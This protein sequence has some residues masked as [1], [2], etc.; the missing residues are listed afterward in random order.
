MSGSTMKSLFVVQ[1]EGPCPCRPRPSDWRTRS[2]A[3][4]GRTSPARPRLVTAG[5]AARADHRRVQ[6]VEGGSCGAPQAGKLVTHGAAT[7]FARSGTFA[8]TSASR[9]Q[10]SC[11]ALFGALVRDGSQLPGHRTAT[12]THVDQGSRLGVVRYGSPMPSGGIRSRSTCSQIAWRS[13]N[14]LRWCLRSR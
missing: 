8:S 1:A 14:T 3:C 2:P 5:D 10:A 12:A 13:S 11:A 9:T 4:S 6:V 7:G